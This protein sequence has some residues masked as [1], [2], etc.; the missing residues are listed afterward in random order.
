LQQ[1][2]IADSSVL[3]NFAIINEL[4]LLNH[5]FKKIFIPQEV[6]DEIVVKGKGK[7]GC[8]EVITTIKN[9]WFEVVS[10]QD[11]TLFNY[12]KR[13]LILEKHPV[14]PLR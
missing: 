9:K 5:Y 1:K 12:W 8:Q 13:I 7:P 14:L 11:K 3:I 2:V 4:R 10:V 6:Y